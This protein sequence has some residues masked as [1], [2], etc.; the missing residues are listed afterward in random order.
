LDPNHIKLV[1]GITLDFEISTIF[2]SER[3]IDMKLIT[4]TLFFFKYDMDIRL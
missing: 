2:E 3:D 4:D 1:K